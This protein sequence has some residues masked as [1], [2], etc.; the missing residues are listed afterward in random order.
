MSTPALI[1]VLGQVAREPSARARIARSAEGA[2]AA[3]LRS[4]Q[5]CG[6]RLGALEQAPDGAPRP[7]LGWHWSLSHAG[8]H[9]A[10]VVARERVGVD[11]EARER[12]RPEL[13]EAALDSRERELLAQ[14]ENDEGL[15]FVRGWTAKE[16]VLKKLGVGLSALSRCRIVAVP[17][18]ERLE[19][20]HDGEAHQVEQLV[21]ERAVAAVSLDGPPREVRWH[22]ETGAW[23]G[24]WDRE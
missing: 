16:A 9:V 7:S 17:S 11:I 6:A 1:V 4:A 21:L 10:G 5:L 3:V 14:R 13:V 20:E 23:T 12:C 22:A 8:L 2:R 15:A 19:I 18:T 24:S